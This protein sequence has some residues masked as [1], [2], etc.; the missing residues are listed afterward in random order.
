M[1]AL[2]ILIIRHAEKQGESWPGSGL[3]P[4]GGVSNGSAALAITRTFRAKHESMFV[5]RNSL[6]GART[7]SSRDR[8]PLKR[9]ERSRSVLASTESLGQC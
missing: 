4:D 6:L 8:A 2:T 3:M 1:S 7:H 5:W 9:K